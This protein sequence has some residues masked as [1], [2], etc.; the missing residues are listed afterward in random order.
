MTSEICIMNTLGVV[1]AAD[2]A[3][4]ISGGQSAK[5]YNTVNKLFG[6]N[7]H[8]IGI[9]INGNANFNKLSLGIVIKEFKKNLGK[10]KLQSVDD[11][12]TNFIEFLDQFPEAK[13]TYAEIEMI[14][15]YSH[16][17]LDNVLQRSQLYINDILASDG[18]INDEQ[19]RQI[20]L[21]SIN[22]LCNLITYTTNIV[23][24]IDKD[25]LITNYQKLMHTIIVSAFNNDI[26]DDEIKSAFVN[27]I[28]LTLQSDI[29]IID[30]S[31]L[32]IA[33][34][35][36][37]QVLPTMIELELHGSFNGNILYL[38]KQSDYIS[39][40]ENKLSTIIP[41]A[42]TDMIDTVIN[43]SHPLVD[44][45]IVRTINDSSLNSEEK[46][47][48]ISRI[49]EFKNSK[50]ISPFKETIVHLP[51]EELPHM[52]E[53]FIN[54]TSFK[55]KYSQNIESVGGPVDIL[56]ITKGEGPIWINR[57]HYFDATHNVEYLNRKSDYNAIN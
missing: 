43:G 33:G 50:F 10:E 27:L 37:E 55:R 49:D 46:N 5:T 48:I 19:V 40:E 34:Y 44:E 39:I 15:S 38:K 18:K 17:L 4:T 6:L 53:T 45:Y 20:V 8:D 29:E 1:L 22:E 25:Y 14:T 30:K 52:A 26:P 41:F 35:G 9:M 57:K 56:T 23:F 32:I 12:V 51:L 21:H 42:Q 28:F 36:A 13:T 2:S 31:S 7:T 24:I 3:V 47:A 16:Q 54:L 11:Y